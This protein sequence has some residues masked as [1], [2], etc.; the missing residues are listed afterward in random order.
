MSDD[1]EFCV[2]P[3]TSDLAVNPF[4]CRQQSW[5][6]SPLLLHAV[7]ALCYQHMGRASD[8]CYR[9]AIDHREEALKLLED[10]SP[11]EAQSTNSS[12]QSITSDLHLLDPILVMF[13]FEVKSS[14]SRSWRRQL[15]SV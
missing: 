7:L 13:T 5:R 6:T 12:V 14:A 11:R 4:R 15:T 8:K 3:L 2:L 1:S 10:A 9:R